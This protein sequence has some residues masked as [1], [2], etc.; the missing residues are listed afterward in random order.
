[1]KMTTYVAALVFLAAG[2]MG[3]A[4]QPVEFH[5]A[6]LKVAVETE[7]GIMDPTPADML[8]LTHLNARQRGI[9]DLSGLES[10]LNLRSLWLGRNHIS[11]ISVLSGLV[12]LEHLELSDN[13][14]GDEDMAALSESIY[15]IHLDLAGNAIT[16]ISIVSEMRFLGTLWLGRNRISDISSLSALSYLEN[17]GL[18][19]NLLDNDDMS[20][21]QISWL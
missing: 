6:N 10:A 4:Q 7:L 1:M 20:M 18:G 9:I 21:L 19:T 13:R 3:F 15:L 16:D 8:S 11:D 5:D 12:P 14:L 2:K 17:L